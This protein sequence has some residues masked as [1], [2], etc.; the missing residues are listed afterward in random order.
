MKLLSVIAALILFVFITCEANCSELIF[1]FVSPSFGGNPL[2][3]SFLI[4]QAQLQNKFKEKTEE[5]PLLEQFEPMYQAQYLSAILDEA[6]KNN[7]ENLVDGTY[8]IGGLTVNVTKDSVNHVITLLVSDP[9]TGRQT[10]FQIP[11]TP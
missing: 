10:T 11:Y 9:S 2:N 1:Q 8:V 5:K 6:Y 7:G 3:G 4:Q